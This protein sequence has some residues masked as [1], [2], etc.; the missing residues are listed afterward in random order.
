M[1]KIIC[2]IAL[3][4]IL[5]SLVSAETCYG[6]KA[7]NEPINISQVANASY[8]NITKVK[9]PNSSTAVSNIVMTK[10]GVSFEYEFTGTSELGVY[11]VEGI[12][13][14]DVWTCDFE[15]T[16]I[17]DELTTARSILFLGLIFILL[18]LFVMILV[19]VPMLPSQDFKTDEKNIIDINWLKY[20]RPVLWGIAYNLLVAIVFLT[21]NV[22]LAYLPNDMFGNFLFMLFKIM[23]ILNL[24]IIVIWFLYTF[25]KIFDDREVKRMLE[26]GVELETQ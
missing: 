12:C 21:S 9:Y 18:V 17:G 25:K 15:V 3:S 14:T 20:L 5:M 2:F 24:P 10:D 6:V 4:L 13:G 22:A 8:C 11:L 16:G 23:F 7:Q 26:R 1:K 19:F